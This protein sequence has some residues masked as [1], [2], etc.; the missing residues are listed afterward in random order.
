MIRYLRKHGFWVTDIDG[1]HHYMTDGT[2]ETCVP[3]HGDK[4]ELN[5]KTQASILKQAGLK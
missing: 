4:R 5:P 3:V 2:H 1:S